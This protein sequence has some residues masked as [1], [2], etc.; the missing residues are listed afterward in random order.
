MNAFKGGDCEESQP[1][2]DFDP[3]NLSKPKKLMQPVQ[4]Q[5][6]LVPLTQEEEM[7]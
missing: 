4:K 5:V 1:L 6:D 3:F 7:L 2:T